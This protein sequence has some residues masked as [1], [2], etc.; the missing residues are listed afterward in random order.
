MFMSFG[1]G[2][3]LDLM[4]FLEPVQRD[5]YADALHGFGAD[6]GGGPITDCVERSA[7]FLCDSVLKP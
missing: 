7:R 6:E 2:S 5:G 1:L 4:P 3:A